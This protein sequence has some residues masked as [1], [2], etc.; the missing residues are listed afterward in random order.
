MMMMMMM[1][2]MNV[3]LKAIYAKLEAVN[4]RVPL[5]KCCRLCLWLFMKLFKTDNK[6][7]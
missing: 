4:R 3:V 6:T 5:N 2:M 1:M 7:P